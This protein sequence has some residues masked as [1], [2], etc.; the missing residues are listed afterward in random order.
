M[1]Q[2]ETTAKVD[3]LADL[4]FEFLAWHAAK[5]TINANKALTAIMQSEIS[6][7]AKKAA[8]QQTDTVGGTLANAIAARLAKPFPQ[9]LQI[10]PALDAQCFALKEEQTEFLTRFLTSYKANLKTS[11]ETNY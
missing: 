2:I 4:V 5:E 1:S 8:I 6:L 3:V 7:Q 11:D 10:D 9:A